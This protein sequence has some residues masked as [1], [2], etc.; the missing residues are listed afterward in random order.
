MAVGPTEPPGSPEDLDTLVGRAFRVAGRSVAELARS[1]GY[2]VP[3][4]LSRHKGFVGQLLEVVLGADAGSESRPDFTRLGVELKTLP[5]RGNGAPTQSTFV[6]KAQID[7]TEPFDFKSTALWHKLACV[8][9]V[10]VEGDT[11]IPLGER[12]FG[13]PFL[14]RPD[15]EDLRRLEADWTAISERIRAGE[16][17]QVTGHEGE[18]L[19]LRPKGVDGRERV[20]GLGAEGWLVPMPPRGWY[21]RPGF[22]ASLIDRAFGSGA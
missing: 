10:P 7:G 20:L 5:I 21:L 9:F 8:L 16:L 19:Q 1:A 18:I 15:A 12:R 13:M 2:R 14:W 17:E 11:S 4:R 6:C 3:A 22:T